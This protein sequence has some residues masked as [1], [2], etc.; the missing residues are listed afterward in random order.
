MLTFHHTAED[1]MLFPLL[2]AQGNE[3]LRKV[4][5]RLAAEHRIV[6]ALIERMEEAAA[7]SI[8]APGPQTFARLKE[9]FEILERVVVS[10]FG[11]EQEELEE[12]IGFY[13]IPF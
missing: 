2:A 10:H 1:R 4:V 12:A 13:E 8:D 11:Y 3:G 9:A 5:E 6:H 7:A